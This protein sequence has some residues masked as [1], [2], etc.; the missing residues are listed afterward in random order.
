MPVSLEHRRVGDVTI[1]T[2]TGRIVE[3]TESGAIR[4]LLDRLFP[5]GPHLVLNLGAVDFIDSSGLGLLVR[6]LHR[7]RSMHGDLKLCALT[8]RMIEALEVTHLRP[9]FDAH[10]SEDEAIGAFYQRAVTGEAVPRLPRDILCVAASS[11]LQAYLR[12]LLAQAGYGVLTAGNLPDGL[13]LLQAMRPKLVV[14]ETELRQARETRTAQKFN[15]LAD[16]LAVIELPEDFSRQ[17]AAIAGER[18][19]ERVRAAIAP[20]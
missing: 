7:A 16:A 10:A 14:V 8:P 4:E 18:L 13:I 1:V 5:E 20:S 12:G 15:A 17:D 2:C 19:L 3:G 9:V 11:D 6:Y